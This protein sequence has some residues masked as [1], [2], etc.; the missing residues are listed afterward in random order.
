M[1]ATRQLKPMVLIVEDNEDLQDL[2][3]LELS[4]DFLVLQAT[5]TQEANFL[6][7]Q[8]GEYLF[9]VILDGNLGNENSLEL[10]M[11]IKADRYTGE[12]IA[13]SNH[14]RLQDELVEAGCRRNASKADLPMLLQ[15]LVHAASAPG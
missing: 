4:R 1:T 8:L 5:T 11:R 9:A 3:K 7:R 12:L 15:S 6:Y 13:N 14:N 2:Y 10:A